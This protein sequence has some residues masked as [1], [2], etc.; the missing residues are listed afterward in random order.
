M[1]SSIFRL[2][3]QKGWRKNLE[4]SESNPEVLLSR[5]QELICP[6]AEFDW[7]CNWRHRLSPQFGSVRLSQVRFPLAPL[8]CIETIVDA[9][10]E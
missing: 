1:S 9:E 6:T 3:V 7:M 5:V 8:S 10:G 4:A 2:T